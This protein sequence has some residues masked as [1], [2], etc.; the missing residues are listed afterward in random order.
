[1]KALLLVAALVMSTSAS[2]SMN[3]EFMGSQQLP[4]GAWA[5][6]TLLTGDSEPLLLP[7]VKEA[8]ADKKY[9]QASSDRR[10]ET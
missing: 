6:G 2:A 10:R 7:L 5:Q 1:M 4:C 9:R 3:K 8:K